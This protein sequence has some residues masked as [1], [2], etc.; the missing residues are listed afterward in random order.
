M[1][2]YLLA[3]AL[4]LLLGWLLVRRRRTRIAA[5]AASR[6]T[7]KPE[8]TRFHAVS[9]RFEAFAASQA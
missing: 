4:A 3:L 2:I 5:E 8:D 9:I 6:A 1:T 7:Y